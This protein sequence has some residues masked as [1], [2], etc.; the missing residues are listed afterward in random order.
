MWYQCCPVHCEYKCSGQ[1]HLQGPHYRDKE[2]NIFWQFILWQQE[3]LCRLE[4]FSLVTVLFLYK[5]GIEL[6]T[7]PVTYVSSILIANWYLFQ[8]SIGNI[9]IIC[10]QTVSCMPNSFAF[11]R[12]RN[13][14][15]FQF[16]CRY[17]NCVGWMP[18]SQFI[19]DIACQKI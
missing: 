6:S 9:Q 18:L 8:Y 4:E 3:R 1:C 5:V 2:G 16:E 19:E 14:N 7:C 12:W 10:F 11:C 13:I 15:N 17:P